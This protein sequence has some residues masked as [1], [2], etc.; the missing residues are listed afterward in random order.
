SLYAGHVGLVGVQQ[1]AR[2]R[3]KKRGQPRWGSGAVVVAGRLLP[4]SAAVPVGTNGPVVLQAGITQIAAPLGCCANARFFNRVV[5]SVW[6]KRVAIHKGVAR[7]DEGTTVDGAH[8]VLVAF[9]AL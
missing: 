4:R 5:A 3:P 8:G 2:A 1:I 7:E 6:P 9:K